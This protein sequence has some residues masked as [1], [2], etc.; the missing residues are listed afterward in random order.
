MWDLAFMTIFINHPLYV[1]YFSYFQ[2]KTGMLQISPFKS[3]T[4]LSGPRHA[5]LQYHMTLLDGSNT[6]CNDAVK[7]DSHIWI[8]TLK[9]LVNLELP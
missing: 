1:G 9:A 3:L 7:N 5:V 4:F 2:C 8:I 6:I